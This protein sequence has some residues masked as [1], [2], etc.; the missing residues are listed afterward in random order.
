[1]NHNNVQSLFIFSQVF[2]YPNGTDAEALKPV[3]TNEIRD[4][5]SNLKTFSH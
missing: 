4:K 1:M 2:I 5:V 3:I